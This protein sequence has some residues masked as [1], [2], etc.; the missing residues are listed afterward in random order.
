MNAFMS[1]GLINFIS[2]VSVWY[3]PEDSPTRCLA[4]DIDG[5][6]FVKGLSILPFSQAISVTAGEGTGNRP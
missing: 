1:A 3:L 5:S 2:V 6:S 4:E